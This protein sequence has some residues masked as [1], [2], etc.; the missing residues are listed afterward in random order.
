[1]SKDSTQGERL[2]RVETKQEN[3]EKMI[4]HFALKLSGIV[5][6]FNNM[7]EL[8]EEKLSEIYKQHF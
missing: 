8:H 2:T 7:R 6:K 5:D 1:M 4:D 3:F